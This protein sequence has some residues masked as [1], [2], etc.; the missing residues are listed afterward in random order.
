[1]VL[2]DRGSRGCRRL[3]YAPFVLLKPRGPES[4]FGAQARGRALRDASTTRQGPRDQSGNGMA[5]RSCPQRPTA[6][7]RTVEPHCELNF[8]GPSSVGA[9]PAANNTHRS[10]S[11]LRTYSL[12]HEFKQT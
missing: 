11:L 8:S 3:Q 7:L 10:S 9:H 5:N 6:L 2:L 4:K 12:V 1:M